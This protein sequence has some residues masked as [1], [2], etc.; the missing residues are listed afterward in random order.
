LTAGPSY[1]VPSAW[2]DAPEQFAQ[3][4]S[5]PK[6]SAQPDIEMNV[7]SAGDAA[8]DKD[9]AAIAGSP[10]SMGCRQCIDH[11]FCACECRP[12]ELC[13]GLAA[14]FKKTER[15]FLKRN[16]VFF[17]GIVTVTLLIVGLSIN[18]PVLSQAGQVIHCNEYLSGHM[19]TGE[20]ATWLFENTRT[21][22]VTFSNCGSNFDSAMYL[23]E[24]DLIDYEP[25]PSPNIWYLDTGDLSD[26]HESLNSCHDDC[27]CGYGMQEK[28]TMSELDEGPYTLQFGPYSSGSEGGHYKVEVICDDTGAPLLFIIAMSFAMLFTVMGS[29]RIKWKYCCCKCKAFVWFLLGVGC[30]LAPLIETIYTLFTLN[31]VSSGTT[32]NCDIA[33]FVVLCLMTMMSCKLERQQNAE[34]DQA[35][36]SKPM[37]EGLD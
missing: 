9:A 16:V 2:K 32:M 4:L 12:D 31:N 24:G 13:Q 30:S 8:V 14:C 37:M 35:V 23:F 34:Q 18:D 6:S 29:V 22:T 19:S 21:R 7:M 27:G 15:C 3:P 1:V 36:Q 26:S 28:F 11:Y 10:E 33:G 25:T 5:D 17:L 20:S